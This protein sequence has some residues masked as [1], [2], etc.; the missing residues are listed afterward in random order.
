MEIKDL[1]DVVGHD[2]D[3]SIMEAV[4]SAAMESLTKAFWHD[5]VC[6]CKESGQGLT[7]RYSPGENG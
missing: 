7:G 4:G 1:L 6:S 2:L 5:L 3:F